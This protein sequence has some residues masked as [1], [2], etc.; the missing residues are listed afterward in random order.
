V[1][2]NFLTTQFIPSKLLEV[3]FVRNS[4][5]TLTNTLQCKTSCSFAIKGYEHTGQPPVYTLDLKL[6]SSL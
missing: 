5:F 3:Q 2:L 4:T 1:A 6:D